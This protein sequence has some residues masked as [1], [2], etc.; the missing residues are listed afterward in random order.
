MV[1]STKLYDLLGVDPKA[2]STEIKKAYRKKSL[3]N[4]PDKNPHLPQEESSRIFAGINEAYETLIDPESRD[5]Y[6]RY[7]EEDRRGGGGGGGM[8]PDMDD[9]LAQMFGGGMGGMGGGGFQKRRKRARGQDTVLPYKVT[10]K[11]LFNGKT[12]HFSLTKDVICSNCSGSGAKLGAGVKPCVKCK[13]QG[14]VLQQR[15]VGNGMISQSWSECD[16]CKG[17]GEK[18]RDKD[19]CKRCKGNKV[20]KEK[21]KLELNIERGMV[22]GQRIVFEGEN[23]QEPGVEKPG[24]IIIQLKLEES[25]RED[26]GFQLKG[27]DLMTTVRLNLSEAL[28]GFSR[29]ILTHLDGRRIRLDRKTITRPGTLEKIQGEGMWR[30][31]DRDLFRGD[32]Y[33][34]FEVDFPNQEELSEE[35]RRVLERVLPAKKEDILGGSPRQA[36]EVEDQVE[37]VEM[38][39][40]N[41][42]EFGSNTV[43]KGPSGGEDDYEDGWED[44]DGY[45]G[46]GPGVQCAQQ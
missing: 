10:L 5:A 39:K 18:V 16:E 6:D 1:A 45:P 19:R 13:G 37:E 46:D 21:T 14:R 40:A 23:D 12:A 24:D 25:E 30:H 8:Q 4:H 7:G 44:E 20:V 29:T 34:R 36:G 9:F 35:D 3:E 38:S 27:L 41:E 42:H 15:S 11:D 31:R 33:V 32:L 43:R 2:N 22:D 17:E 28:L 26:H